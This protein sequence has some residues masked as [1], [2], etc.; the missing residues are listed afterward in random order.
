V[1]QTAW[2]L[3]CQPHDVP[4]LISSRLLKPLGSP[5]QNA[6]KYFSSSEVTEM[7]KDR[8]WLGKMTQTIN[9]HWKTRNSRQKSHSRNNSESGLYLNSVPTAS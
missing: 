9:Q 5:Q 4:I 7:A 8:A 1:E 6:I 2:V 3:G